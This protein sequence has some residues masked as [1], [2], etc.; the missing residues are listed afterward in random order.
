[1][2]PSFATL[3]TLL[4]LTGMPPAASA[5]TICFAPCGSSP[6]LPPAELAPPIGI[7]PIDPGGIGPIDPGGVFHVV[8]G[9]STL[10]TPISTAGL[11]VVHVPSGVF[12]APGLDWR[13]N[14]D[15]VVD[16]SVQLDVGMG[17]VELCAG[18][19]EPFA[20]GDT[21][22]SADPF[23][24][25]IASN[26]TAPLELWSAGDIIVTSTPIPEPSTAL[27]LALG[28]V[29]LGRGVRRLRYT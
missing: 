8:L 11:M 10:G 27:L 29:A 2:R 16:A 17:H 6:G 14:G 5:I 3:V 18:G 13:A 28:L 22:F 23:H 20:D 1:M 25:T 21:R 19:C 24:V 15:V 26:L 7:G 9:P 12:S 4:A